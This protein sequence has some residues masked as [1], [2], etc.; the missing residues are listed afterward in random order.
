MCF[1]VYHNNFE[2]ASTPLCRHTIVFGGPSCLLGLDLVVLDLLGH[3]VGLIDVCIQFVLGIFACRN[4]GGLGWFGRSL[5]TCVIL[6]ATHQASNGT[7]S[8]G[9]A[10]VG[11]KCQFDSD[12][13]MLNQ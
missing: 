1:I 13:L 12:W 8:Q 11:I 2:F 5:W 10:L 4:F 6:L 3:S 9:P 7:S